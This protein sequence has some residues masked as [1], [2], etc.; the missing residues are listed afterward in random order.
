MPVPRF[1]QRAAERRYRERPDKQSR[2]V[3][4]AEEDLI[5]TCVKRTDGGVCCCIGGRSRGRSPSATR[6]RTASV[7]RRMR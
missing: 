5:V 2:E 3:I 7:A 4:E 1:L 6:P